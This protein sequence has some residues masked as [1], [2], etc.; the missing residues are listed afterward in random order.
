MEEKF[1]RMEEQLKRISQSN[2]NFR[3]PFENGCKQV[4][5]VPVQPYIFPDNISE[6]ELRIQGSE[7]LQGKRKPNGPIEYKIVSKKVK[8]ECKILNRRSLLLTNF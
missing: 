7:I 3:M 8:K 4:A 6:N 1:T 5:V 2:A